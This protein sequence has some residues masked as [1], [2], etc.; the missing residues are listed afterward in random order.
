[1]VEVRRINKSLTGLFI[2][3]LLALSLVV[4]NIGM[5]KAES[6]NPFENAVPVTT[7]TYKG[8]FSKSNRVDILHTATD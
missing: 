6:D 2:V 8:E 1:M 7:G 3:G 5:A 4:A